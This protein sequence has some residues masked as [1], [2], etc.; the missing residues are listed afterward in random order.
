[1]L[2]SSSGAARLSSQKATA[3]Y[4]TNET[5][6]PARIPTGKFFLGS[7]TSPDIAAPASI[8]VTAGKNIAKTTQNGAFVKFPQSTIFVSVPPFPMKKEISEP[9]I[10]AIITNWIFIA[11]FALIREITSNANKTTVETKCGL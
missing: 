2:T 11:T 9:T 10:I 7:L 4:I 3:I 6:M 5:P 1:M 8:P